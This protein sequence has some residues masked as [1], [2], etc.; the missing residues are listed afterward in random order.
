MLLAI[1]DA[2][3]ANSQPIGDLDGKDYKHC[4]LVVGLRV[5]QSKQKSGTSFQ[6]CFFMA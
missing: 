4:H 6:C 5:A 3:D 1:C 2:V